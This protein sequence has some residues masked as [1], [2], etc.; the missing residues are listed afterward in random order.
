MARVPLAILAIGV[1]LAAACGGEASGDGILPQAPAPIAQLIGPWQPQ[2]FVPRSGD[3]QPRRTN[4]SPRHG[5]RAGN[6]CRARRR[7]WRRGRGGAHGRPGR[8]HVR[9]LEIEREEG[10][11]ARAAVGLQAASSWHQSKRPSWRKPNS[12]RSA[13]AT[14]RSRDGRWSAVPDRALH[15]SRSSPSV[16]RR[17]SPRSR[18]AG[19]PGGGLRTCRRTDSEIL[20]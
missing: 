20:P 3:A 10:S 4:L 17:F 9:C 13:A 7:S 5:A 8:R 16:A 6:C 12:G 18:T 15:R 11:P 2:P 1:L 14:S 19:S